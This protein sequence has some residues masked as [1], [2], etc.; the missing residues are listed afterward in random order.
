MD[1]TLCRYHPAQPATW[2][3]PSCQHAYG[4]CCIPLNADAPD[5]A[6]RCPLCVGQLH[7]LGAANTAQPFWER[8][9][10]FFTYALQGGPLAFAGI[11]ALAGLF[12]PRM[13]IL[14]IILFSVATKYFH[15]VIEASSQA[16]KEAPSLASAFTTEGL[17]LFFKQLAVFLIAFAALWLAAD[18]NS[19]AI[20]WAVNIGLLLVMP[21][22][23]IRLALDKELGAALSP[24]QVGQVITAMGWRYLIL[25]GFLFILWQSPGWVTYMLSSGLPRVV[26]VP[27]ATFLFA[28]FGVV[29][30]AMMGYAVFQYQGPLGYVI[31]DDDSGQ[32]SYPAPEFLRR[33]ALAEAEIRLKEGQSAQALE[34]LTVAL[35]R[36]P[37]DLKLN[38]RFHQLLYGL[39]ARE[40]CLRHLDHY[41]PLAT[42]LNPAQ[43]AQALLNARQLKADYLP[44]DPL[45]C[46]RLADALLQRHKTRE[47]LSLLRN[48]HQ[49]F[50]DYPHIPRAYLLAARG[51]AEGLGQ[52]E[53]AQK[54]LA[55]IRARYPQSPLLAEVASLE[56]TLEKLVER[57]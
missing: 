28:Y 6:P 46:E 40:R 29:M 33:R 22:S 24:D 5:D 48:L 37:N 27:I 57:G 3:C 54:L 9:P 36:D 10:S 8:I 18:F 16:V 19:E 21:A 2:Q 14:W 45:V 34:T 41:L 13:I 30:C 31:A 17:S 53:P 25:C 43:A 39:N 51:F 4:D 55:F 15:S 44:D 32:A 52:V 56:N 38:E 11:L 49:R 23:I 12:M 47:G 42:R 50:P 26:L 7:F 20:Y 35:E 1:K